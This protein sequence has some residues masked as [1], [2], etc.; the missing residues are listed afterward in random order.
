MI[1]I[2]NIFDNYVEHNNN[3]SNVTCFNEY[4]HL[5]KWYMTLSKQPHKCFEFLHS[6]ILN[7][8]IFPSDVRKWQGRYKHA[9][10]TAK[11]KLINKTCCWF[12]DTY[13]DRPCSPCSS[14]AWNQFKINGTPLSL[15][16][17]SLERSWADTTHL[18]LNLFWFWTGFMICGVRLFFLLRYPTKNWWKFASFIQ[19]RLRINASFVWNR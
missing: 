1:R 7:I 13:Q 2:R 10:T 14:R 17:S 8:A 5:Y 19:R 4:L 6:P 11:K 15:S 16:L 3:C 12:T 18:H 9:K